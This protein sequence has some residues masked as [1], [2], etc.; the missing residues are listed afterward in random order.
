MVR[1]YKITVTGR[2][3]GVFYRLS[4]QEQAAAL[5]LRGYV[6]NRP[7]GSVYIEAEGEEE[8]LG[9]LAEWCRRGPS[10]A[11]VDQV[12]IVQGEPEGYGKFEVRR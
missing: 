11:R 8:D 9:K 2:V 5:G 1:H 7:D 4:T 6:M 12:D 3:Q 10:G